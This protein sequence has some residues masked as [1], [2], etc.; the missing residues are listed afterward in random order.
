[1]EGYGEALTVCFESR[2]NNEFKAALQL[3]ACL[4]FGHTVLFLALHFGGSTAEKCNQNFNREFLSPFIWPWPKSR[5]SRK[6]LFIQEPP[7][8]YFDILISQAS[9]G[10]TFGKD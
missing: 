3:L 2:D 8:N 9:F 1:L 4:I 5:G 7:S 6:G 10:T